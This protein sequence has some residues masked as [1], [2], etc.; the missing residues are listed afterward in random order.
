MEA[1]YVRVVTVERDFDDIILSIEG[2]VVDVEDQKVN[3]RSVF[4]HQTA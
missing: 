4:V 2:I 1:F 3:I